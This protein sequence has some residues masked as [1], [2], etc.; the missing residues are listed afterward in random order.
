MDRRKKIRV[1]NSL[2]YCKDRID[3][4][5]KQA[6]HVVSSNSNYLFLSHGWLQCWRA[7]QEAQWQRIHLQC[8]RC[9]FD[10]WV[11]KIPWRRERQPSPVFLPGESHGQRS[12]AGYSSWGPKELDMTE[13]ISTL[14][15]K[16]ARVW[17][18]LNHFFDIHFRAGIL[19]FF[20]LSAFR[21]LFWEL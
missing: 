2:R 15:W 7:L 18:L 13:C 11:W 14:E 9:G 21:A 5:I 10:P 16:E 8:R 19:F 1:K 12:L 17:A 20:P 4:Y 3:C 6:P